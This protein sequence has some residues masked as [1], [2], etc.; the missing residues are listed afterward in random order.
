VEAIGPALC[1]AIAHQLVHAEQDCGGA[2][3]RRHPGHGG[4]VVGVLRNERPGARGHCS[5]AASSQPD[6]F[7]PTHS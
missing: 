5:A 4:G 3:A 1:T 6:S 2:A 7:A